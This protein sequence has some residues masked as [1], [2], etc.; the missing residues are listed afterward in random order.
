MELEHRG[1]PCT[2]HAQDLKAP[3]HGPVAGKSVSA[4]AGPGCVQGRVGQVPKDPDHQGQGHRSEEA[5]QPLCPGPQGRTW[6]A[7]KAPWGPGDAATHSG[8]NQTVGSWQVTDPTEAAGS[9]DSPPIPATLV[10]PGA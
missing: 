3:Q 8:G 10:Q 4:K 7:T 9:G 1:A 2:P 5:P 6:R